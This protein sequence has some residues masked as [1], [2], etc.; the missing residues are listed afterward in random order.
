MSE[1]TGQT[2]PDRRENRRENL[3]L[4]AGMLAGPVAW[5]LQFQ[6][7]YSLVQSACEAGHKLALHLVTLGALLLVSGGAVVSGRRLQR[8]PEGPADEGDD[9]GTRARFMALSGLG[10]SLFFTLL[11]VAAEIPNWILRACD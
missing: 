1:A 11:I 5:L 4:W 3:A 2:R 8:L 9:H 7:N 6:I 10:L